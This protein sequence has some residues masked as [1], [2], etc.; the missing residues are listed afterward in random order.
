MSEVDRLVPS[1]WQCGRDE[2]LRSSQTE[3]AK[4]P[5]RARRFIHRLPPIPNNLGR[6]GETSLPH[7]SARDEPIHLSWIQFR[8]LKLLI[9]SRA[10]RMAAALDFRRRCLRNMKLL[11]LVLAGFAVGG[12]GRND[13]AERA[14]RSHEAN[15]PNGPLVLGFWPG[16]PRRF[17]LEKAQTLT[18]TGLAVESSN[19]RVVELPKVEV[20]QLP[21]VVELTFHQ[22]RLLSVY[23][24]FRT[25]DPLEIRRVRE[26]LTSSYGSPTYSKSTPTSDFQQWMVKKP[27]PFTV[28]SGTPPGQ[29]FYVTCWE[30]GPLFQ[31]ALTSINANREIDERRIKEYAKASGR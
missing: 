16:E 31:S 10:W 17:A 7:P 9:L 8:G 27:L 30:A 18:K 13:E 19:A 1:R 22:D 6:F 25:R 12:C 20:A 26:M 3:W 11:A 28:V 29:L 15:T 2:R 24:G 4:R 5:I 21:C 14:A 23:V